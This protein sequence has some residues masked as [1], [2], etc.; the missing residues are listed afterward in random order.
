MIID[1]DEQHSTMTLNLPNSPNIYPTFHTSEN[2]PYIES[3]TTLF[4]SCLFEEP[5]P[6]TTEEG[7]EEYFIKQIL[8]T[9][10]HGRSYQYLVHW[11]GYG[12]EHDKW[13]LVTEFG[14][15][16]LWGFSDGRG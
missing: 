2:L 10:C 3:N 9:H 16:K 6:I 5:S 7:D 12:H 11:W 14:T 8:D 15:A 1:V 4:P 13:L